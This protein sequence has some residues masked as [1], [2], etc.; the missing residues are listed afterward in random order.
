VIITQARFWL[1]CSHLALQVGHVHVAVLVALGHHHLHAHHLGAGG[2]GAVRAAWDQADVAVRVALGRVV[3]LDGQQA[4]V[5]ALA[6]CVGLQADA[7]VAR[8]LAQPGAQLLV[9]QAV[10]FEL[11]G[12]RERMHVGELGPGDRDHLARG[13]ELHGARAQRDHGAV[14]RQ[15]LVRE[16]ADVAQHAGLGVVRVEHRVREVAAGAAQRGGDHQFDMGFQR[17]HRGQGLSILGEEGPDQR[18]VLTRGGLVQ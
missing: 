16:L 13:V 4:G 9:E 15:V 2:V 12:R 3:G 18:E 11:V 1:C 17:L 10:A 6:A 5:F 8:G 14:Q 7:R